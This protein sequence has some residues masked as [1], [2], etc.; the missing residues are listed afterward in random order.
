MKPTV[1]ET[2][3]DIRLEGSGAVVMLEGGKSCKGCGAARIGLCKAGGSVMFLTA[4]NTACSQAGDQVIIGIDRKT[5][6]TGYLLAYLI[7]LISFIAGAVSGRLAG[8]R[9]GLESLDVLL[10]FVFFGAASL[11]TFIRLR[12][13]DRSCQ[14][15]VKRVVSDGEFREFP[16]SEEERLYLQHTSQC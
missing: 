10:S 4:R 6:R 8:G 7:P 12:R 5:Q 15:E 13:L 16:D 11:F 1:P 3:R 14:M 9:L 2:G